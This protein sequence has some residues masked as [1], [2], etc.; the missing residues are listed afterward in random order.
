MD[1]AA[2]Q[3]FTFSAQGNQ[4]FAIPI[5]EAWTIAKDIE[6]NHGTATVHVGPTAFIGLQISPN[7]SS[8][9]GLGSGSGSV[10][11]RRQTPTTT[12]GLDV[13]NVVG[14]TPAAKVGIAAGDVVTKFDGHTI[15]SDSQLTALLVPYHPGQTATITWVT[16]TGESHTA[17][18]TLASGPSA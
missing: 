18:I 13:S 5:S 4:G 3:S 12:N 17:S 15:T 11:A 7:N 16:P 8:G 6:A 1:T 14:G 2:S 10:Q 9:L